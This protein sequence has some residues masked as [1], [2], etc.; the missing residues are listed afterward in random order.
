MEPELGLG[1]VLQVDRRTVTV[2]FPAGDAVR[3]YALASAPLRRARFDVGDRVRDHEGVRLTVER[4]EDRDGSLVYHGG[5]R[6]LPES[7]LADALDAA[8]PDERLAAGDVDDGHAFELRVETL[9]HRHAMRRSAVRGFLGGRL[10]LI[11]HQFFIAHEVAG[12]YAPRVLLADEVGLGKTI[13]ACLIVHRLLVSGRASRVLVLTPS[14]LVHQWLVELIRRF[15]LRFSIFDEE[16][17]AAIMESDSEAN[18]FADDQLVLASLSFLASD[19]WRAEQAADAGWDVL[20]VDEAHHLEWTPEQASAEYRTVEAIAARTPGLLLL[21]ATPE[22]LGEAGHFAR[23]RLLDPE[24]YGSFEGFLREAESYTAVA[25]EAERLVSLANPNDADTELLSK[26]L[27]QHGTGRVMFRNTRHAVG[28]FPQRLPR[29]AR[30]A[31]NGVSTELGRRLAAELAADLDGEPPTY[32]LTGDPR[33]EWLIALLD[34]LG[35]EKLLVICTTKEKAR[36]VDAAVAEKIKVKTALFHED[37]TIVQRDRNAAWFAEPDGARVLLCSEIGSE[38]RNFQFAHHLAMFDVPTDPDL[39]EQRI[40]RLDRIGQSEDIRIHV[41]FVAGSGQE[42]I[43]RWHDEGAGAF[44]HSSPVAAMLFERFGARLRTLATAVAAGSSDD[45]TGAEGLIAETRAAA[46][47]LSAEVESGRDRLLELTSFRPD[48][49]RAVIGEV[50]RHDNSP[51]LEDYFLRLLEAFGIYVEDLGPRTYLLNPDCTPNDEL[52]MLERGDRSVTF[53]RSRAVVREDQELLTWDHPLVETAIEAELGSPRGGAAFSVIDDE[54][55]SVMLLEAVFVLECVAPAALNVDRFLAPTPIRVVVD[56]TE[57]DVTGEYAAGGAGALAGLEDGDG[58]WLTIHK[59]ALRP[60]VR[61]MVKA[62]HEH[63][64]SRVAALVEQ[65]RLELQ[66]IV[67][68]EARR[69]ASL[70]EINDHVRAEEVELAA[71]RFTELDRRLGEARIRLDAL[72]LIW[73]GP[74]E[75]GRP[76]LA[77]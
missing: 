49:A 15:Q 38:G 63:G 64:E 22:Q 4:V 17:A 52:P 53:E 2:R 24:R 41:P 71:S 76:V 5:G 23:L 32:D 51:V 60:A 70:A 74:V 33:I 45:D 39:L 11:P 68:A 13:E 21:T 77:R 72:R 69:L 44:A 1:I 29:L 35:D 12:R 46:T 58:G 73:R 59:Q 25:E 20:V 8:G 75:D 56:Q 26:M 31:P 36:A 16:R 18:P 37:L 6:E 62:A 50:V 54:S 3:T 9:G 30:L 7:L 14:S 48:A 10:D 55:A 66:T 65:A 61:A 34:E 40:G 28:G 47:E 57:A 27:D 43:V 42:A 19:P 67:G